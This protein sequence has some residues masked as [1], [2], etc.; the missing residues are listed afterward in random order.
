M[1]KRDKKIKKKHNRHLSFFK[2]F[3]YVW[4]SALP[5]VVHL[6]HGID[7]FVVEI[8]KTFIILKMFVIPANAGIY[9]IQLMKHLQYPF[10]EIPHTYIF[11]LYTMFIEKKYGFGMTLVYE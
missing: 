3:D 7:Y 10:K 6:L 11:G 8:P 4:F 5:G 2:L 9:P 1:K